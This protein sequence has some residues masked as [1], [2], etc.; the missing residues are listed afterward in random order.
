[1]PGNEGVD[2]PIGNCA[3]SPEQF[4]QIIEVAHPGEIGGG[5]RL[6]GLARPGDEMHFQPFHPRRPRQFADPVIDITADKTDAVACAGAGAGTGGTQPRQKIPPALVVQ[7][8]EQY[9]FQSLKLAG[10]LIV[11]LPGQ[12][13]GKL[14]AGRP[15]I[16]QADNGLGVALNLTGRHQAA[17]NNYLDGLERVPDHLALVLGIMGSYGDAAIMV[18]RDLNREE[19]MNNLDFYR[20]LIPLNSRQRARRIFGVSTA[21]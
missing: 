11:S 18:R 7:N 21:K 3:Q 5:I 8:V 16:T 1:M 14:M 6:Q 2:R 17:E 9:V 20:S 10:H 13:T 15:H 4:E 12:H 19:V